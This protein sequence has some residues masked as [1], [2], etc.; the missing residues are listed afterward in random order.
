MRKKSIFKKYNKIGITLL[1]MVGVIVL[2]IFVSF[3]IS[4]LEEQACW[5]TLYLSVNQAAADLE[6]SIRNDQKILESLATIIAQQDTMECEEV[7]DIINTFQPDT[8]MTRIGLLLPGD[9]L[10][11]PFEPRCDVSGQ[12]SFEEEAALGAHI[13]DRSVDIR[14]KDKLILRNFVPVVKDGETVAMLYGV[15]ELENLPDKWEN[16]PYNG[17]AAVYIIDSKNG[18][19]IMDT[20]HKS[21]GNILELGERSMKNGYSPEQFLEDVLSRQTGYCVFV[22]KTIGEYLYFYF[23]PVEINQWVVAISISEGVAF[24]RLRQINDLLITF[25]VVEILVLA[26][27]FIWLMLTTGK[28]LHEKQKLAELDVL[29]GLQ[30]RNCYERNL[31]LYPGEG[32]ESLTCIYV[33]VNGL[34]ELNNKK[35]HEAGDRMLQKVGHIIQEQFGSKDTYRI[36]GDEFVAFVNDETEETIQK[37]M[38]VIERSLME[39]GYHIS[40]GMCRQE[41]PVD[42]DRLVKQ[43]EKRMYEE[44]KRYYKESGRTRRS[45]D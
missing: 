2:S 31:S 25:N 27:Y 9:R 40:V 15:A 35:G 18:D 11:L 26:G 33:D 43:A 44:K 6:T 30:N 12:L 13:S 28:E 1:V 37:R 5:E 41:L 45:H 23:Q 16:I 3:R 32:K 22:S 38:K 8:V 14:D 17:E 34:H 21:L 42:M 20:W 4:R 24:D 19:F 10:M 29:S 7:Q 39:A 36:G